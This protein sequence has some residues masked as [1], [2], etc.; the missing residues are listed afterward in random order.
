MLALGHYKNPGHPGFFRSKEISTTYADIEASYDL[1]SDHTPIIVTIITTVMNRQPT[2]RLHNSQTNWVTY[3]NIA[4]DKADITMQFKNCKDV[5]AVTD[6]FI[7]VLQ[8]AAQAATPTLNPLRPATNLT[9]EIKSLVAVKR[10]ARS[11]WKKTHSPENHRLY[12]KA[13]NKLK[14]ARHEIWNASFAA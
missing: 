4:R 8:Q 5:E 12:N 3:K 1:I 7:N 2:P 11:R 13:N 6:N 9:S 10:N 14:A